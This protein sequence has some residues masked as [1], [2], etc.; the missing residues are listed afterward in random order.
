M[1]QNKWIGFTNRVNLLNII[2]CIK[3]TKI[4]CRNNLLSYYCDVNSSANPKYTPQQTSISNL[5]H[6][7]GHPARIAV[8]EEIINKK[9]CVEGVVQIE[10][11]L[12]GTTITHLK[13]LQRAGLIKGTFS[14]KEGAC[15]CV[16]W[17]KMDELKELFDMLHREVNHN[18]KEVSEHNCK[19]TK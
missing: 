12:T 15:Y 4:L 10:P 18:K 13:G 7:M 5:F 17:E 16:N 6:A 8:I 19:C 14:S 2:C 11:I 1:I 3:V 9:Q